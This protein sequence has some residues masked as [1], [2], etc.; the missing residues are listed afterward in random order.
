[1]LNFML[2]YGLGSSLMLYFLISLAVFCFCLYCCFVL[3]FLRKFSGLWIVAE[4]NRKNEILFLMEMIG[5]I[6]IVCKHFDDVVMICDHFIVLKN[7]L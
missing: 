6:L 2:G 1:M 5:M 7:E 3:I 4:W